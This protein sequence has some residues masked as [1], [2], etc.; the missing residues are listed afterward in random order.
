MTS[1]KLERRRWSGAK[2]NAA[3]QGFA[4][5]LQEIR[6]GMNHD[7]RGLQ[8]SA[9]VVSNQSECSQLWIRPQSVGR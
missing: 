9:V 5:I 3:R 2:E 1:P 8:R 7:S 6:H 4:L